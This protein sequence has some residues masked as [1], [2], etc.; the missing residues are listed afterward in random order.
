MA[1]GTKSDATKKVAEW[2]SDSQREVPGTHWVEVPGALENM[3]PPCYGRSR[4]RLDQSFC[5]PPGTFQKAN[6]S[7]IAW[8]RLRRY[9]ASATSWQL[10]SACPWGGCCRGRNEGARKTSE[11]EGLDGLTYEVAD[12][13]TANF[14]A[15]TYDAVYFH[16]AL[17][18]VFQLEHLLD[19]I[20]QT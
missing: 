20:K 3:K 11:A 10:L 4:H 9:R 2:W 13:N 19:Q 7:A 12:L 8:M 5:K 14:P 16:S 17:H 1:E 6:Q 15:E 18:H